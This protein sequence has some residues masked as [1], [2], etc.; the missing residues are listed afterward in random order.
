M[1]SF[2]LLV[3]RADERLWP[4]AIRSYQ[5]ASPASPLDETDIRFSFIR[6]SKIQETFFPSNISRRIAHVGE[7]STAYCNMSCAPVEKIAFHRDQFLMRFNAMKHNCASNIFLKK[8]RLIQLIRQQFCAD[9]RR[10]RQF[11]IFQSKV[12][13]LTQSVGSLWC[14]KQFCGIFVGAGRSF[15]HPSSNF[16]ETKFPENL[17]K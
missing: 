8:T 1:L 10:P 14:V 6:S 9:G 13:S 5:T 12:I 2:E 4:D 16:Y 15:H 3:L 11:I 7:S 17:R